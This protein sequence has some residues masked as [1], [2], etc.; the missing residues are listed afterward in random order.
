VDPFTKTVGG[1][2]LWIVVACCLCIFGH[3]AS[4]SLAGGGPEQLLLV[5]NPKS[6]DSMTIANHYVRLR[7]VPAENVLYLPWDPAKDMTDV[8]TFRKEILTPVLK[9]T[10]ARR[11]AARIDY[12]VYSADFPW[13]INTSEDV[14]R[15]M[16]AQKAA[17]EASGQEATD[18]TE[19]AAKS[20]DAG[21]ATADEQDGPKRFIT[22]WPKQLT[23]VGSINGLTYLWERVMSRN[24]A[25][26]MG[27]ETNAYMGRKAA[28]ATDSESRDMATSAFRSNVRF[29]RGG[30]PLETAVFAE[31]M[32]QLQETARRAKLEGGTEVPL[33]LSSLGSRYLISVVLGVT[34]G[35]GNSV[36]EVIDYL[37]RSA[38]VD[39]T[40]PPG[41]IYYVKNNDIRSK[42]R[43]DVFPA[44]VSELEELGVAAEIVEG[45]VPRNKADV[46]GALLGTA[47]FDWKKSKSTILPGAICEH[48]TSLGGVMSADAGQTPLSELLR[49]GASGASGTVT[50]PYAIQAKFP[51]PWIHVHYARGCTLAEAFYQSVYGP[52]Q[53]LIAG[54]PLC[55]P[56]ANIPTVHV[57]GVEEGAT[58]EGVLNLQPTATIPGDSEVS[59]FELFVD[60]SIPARCQPGE[61]LELDTRRLADGYHELRVIA[62][63]AGPIASQGRRVIPITTSNH[64]RKIELAVSPPGKIPAGASLSVSV[65]SPGSMGIALMHNTRMLGR[66]VGEK[67]HVEIAPDKL[68]SGPV[69][70]HAVGLPKDAS[71]GNVVSATVE[72]VLP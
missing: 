41:T 66:I 43:H 2:R 52:Y 64:G 48:L 58:V 20:P 47:S 9:A 62:Y 46:L 8:D 56:W 28:E 12:V 35:R 33:D 68:G 37:R 13:G 59:H 3:A 6:R 54:D 7:D 32:R 22:Q 21:A 44:V 19:D 24:P 10:A 57:E 17:A 45:I 1:S 51:T 55:R 36:E 4:P 72:V 71:Q 30:T 29:A 15:F 40:R 34:S 53:L 39:G 42:T 67:G 31:R 65:K 70:L 18:G 61:S 50:E 27:L 60:G 14:N 5:V 63:E 25:N 16:A 49:H 26:Y 23:K 69:R 11:A 38:A